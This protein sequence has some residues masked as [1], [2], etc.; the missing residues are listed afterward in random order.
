MTTE[1]QAPD[2]D[3][4][5]DLYDLFGPLL[6]MIWDD[7]YHFGYWEGEH[8]TS[9]IEEATDRFTDVLIAK[10]GVTPGQRVLDVGCGIGKPGLRLAK[11]TGAT[12][13]G[14]SINADQVRQANER[15]AA[16]GLA[17]RV[18]FE[19]VNAMSMPFPDASFD[20]VLA[21]ESL[22]HMERPRALKEIARVLAPGGRLVLTDLT[23][24]QDPHDAA[25]Q[26]TKL[27]SLTRLAD[28]PQLI[29]EAG[30]VLEELVDVTAHT[31]YTVPRISENLALHKDEF[32]ARY[33]TDVSQ[34]HNATVSSSVNTADIGC[35]VAV[36]RSA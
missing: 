5:A 4:V 32:E 24:P 15:A 6:S 14:I 3:Q 28:Y 36:V 27:S 29:A 7:N 26:Q 33:K 10:L 35:L 23:A 13:H 19:R 17:D 2:A 9:T 22:V 30:L 11:A 20:A 1:P 31:R 8:D 18:T 34:L 25:D 21:F 12:V 16:E